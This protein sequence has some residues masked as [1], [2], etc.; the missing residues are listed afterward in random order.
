MN[1]STISSENLEQQKILHQN[2]NY[3]V[4]SLSFGRIMA[5]F[6]LQTRVQSVSDYGAGKKTY[7]LGCK[8]MELTR[9]NAILLTM[10]L[11]SMV[12]Q[13]LRI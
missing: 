9:S 11:R 3:G 7:C 13:D 12:S 2:P 4:A 5:D 1:R 10:H 6:I 8:E